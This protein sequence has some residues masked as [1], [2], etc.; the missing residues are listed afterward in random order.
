MHAVLATAAMAARRM[1]LPSLSSQMFSSPTYTAK[2]PIHHYYPHLKHQPTT[3]TTACARTTLPVAA[4]PPP[5]PTPTAAAAAAAAAAAP[6]DTN[7]H[8]PR[9]S[10]VTDV[11][12]NLDFWHAFCD[13]ADAITT[14]GHGRRALRP[15]AHL[16]FGGDSVDKGGRDLAFLESLLELKQR[17]PH[18]VHLVFGNRDINK[19]RLSAE[20]DPKQWLAAADHPGVY[21]RQRGGPD[22]GPA[23]PAT[24]L[25]AQPTSAQ[26]EDTRAARLRYMLAD[27]MGSPRAFE[28]RRAELALSRPAGGRVDDEAVLESYLASLERGGLMRRYLEQAQLAVLIGGNLF[29]H[30]AVRPSSMGVVPGAPSVEADAR[31]WVDELNNFAAEEVKRWA[32]AVDTGRAGL[33]RGR[34]DCY[35]DGDVVSDGAADD[36]DDD[37]QGTSGVT[38]AERWGRGFFDRPGGRLMAYGMARQPDGSLSP[39]VVYASYLNDG[40]PVPLEEEAVR[41][42]ARGGVRTVVVGHQPHGD[43]PVVM[44]CAGLKGDG[45]QAVAE[46]EVDGACSV[47]VITADSSFGGDTVWLED[48]PEGEEPPAAPATDAAAGGGHPAWR[49]AGESATAGGMGVQRMPGARGKPPPSG[50]RPRG[51]SVFDVSLPAGESAGGGVRVTG[52]LSNGESVSYE[53]SDDND[54]GRL[55][56]DGW[57]VK[58]R[59]EG[60][61]LLLS[62]GKGYRVENVAVRG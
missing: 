16:V 48:V 59:L 58:G 5:A 50:P 37:D 61:E 56:A 8:P 47:T 11:E 17:H 6:S 39:T 40:H 31:R 52:R 20:L 51:E 7:T 27:N 32:M 49:P 43:A 19:M 21:W 44:K 15:G 53:V 12:G 25:A 60:G 36:D 4:T 1:A 30:G 28:H 55:R 10:Y 18:N 41:Y 26:R 3:T 38:S 42:L 13:R 45:A 2:T 62:R 57:W 54:V 23:T 46:A 14:D 22:G 9:I 33:W 34:A 24:Y 35:F 29:V